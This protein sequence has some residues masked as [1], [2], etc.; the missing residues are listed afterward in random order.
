MPSDKKD[1]VGHH[2]VDFLSDPEGMTETELDQE[3]NKLN[4]DVH[5]LVNRVKNMVN[6]ALEEDRLAWQGAAKDDRTTVLSRLQEIKSKLLNLPRVKLL[7]QF[8]E[9]KKVAGPKLSVTFRDLD[10]EK[11][12]D[13]DIRDMIVNLIHLENLRSDIDID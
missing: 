4:V 5:P 2:L 3:L 8:E 6:Q 13:D 10:P 1:N 9:M 12:D 7:E 11:M